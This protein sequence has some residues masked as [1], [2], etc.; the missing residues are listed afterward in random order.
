[1]TVDAGRQFVQAT[2]NLEGDGP[3]A[4]Y[5]FEQIEAVFL[6]TQVQ[7]FPNTDAVIRQLTMGQ[8][9]HT[10]QTWKTYAQGCVQPGFDYFINRFRGQL[11]GTVAA[12]KAARLFLPQ[13]ISTMQP[14]ASEVDTLK[15]FPFL[16]NELLLTA[17]KSELPNY[18]ASSSDVALDIDPLSWWKQHSSDLP[19]W[20]TAA[21]LVLLIQPSSAAAERAF[22]ILSALFG[23]CQ[24]CALQDYVEVSLMLQYNR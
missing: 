6:S 7:H 18:L 8:P 5:C 22:S 21:R 1:M 15:V 11:S 20:A 23:D 3:L 12:F 10:A 9:A 2:Y 17:M 19:N 4:L 24:D 16:Q 13:K 14:V